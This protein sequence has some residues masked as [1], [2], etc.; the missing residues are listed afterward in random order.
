LR[1]PLTLL[2]GLPLL[3]A[4]TFPAGVANAVP[5]SPAAATASSAAGAVVDPLLGTRSPLPKDWVGRLTLPAD[6]PI[7]VM[8]GH[9][10]AQNIG[11]SGTSGAAVAAGGA[12]MYRGISD[13]LYWNMV[14]ALA[15]VREGERRGLAIRYH[16]PPV[17]TLLDGDAEG[18]N[19]SVG[20]AHTAAGG[21]ALEIHFDAWGPSGVGSGLI[22]AMTRPFTS[23]DE[24]L[25]QAFGAYPMRF[26]D[27]LGGPKRG[28][29]LLEIG[30]LEGTLEQ[31]L[32]NRASRDATVHAIAVRVV[33]A[34][35][36][37]LGRRPSSSTRRTG[38]VA[39]PAPIS[40]PPGKGR[41]APQ[42]SDPQA[43]SGGG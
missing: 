43:S 23:L 14:I 21:Y 16:R 42:G 33:D 38:R 13:E 36:Q 30:K 2:L 39:G 31:S 6:T 11:G 25:A 32:R 37:G 10:D 24:S 40:R 41:S 5:A 29:S 7:L 1:H 22:P 3:L 20:R 17:R 28:I 18:S 4:Q 15:V 12:P 19:W 8:A 26:R 35:E 9:A 34:L 27:V